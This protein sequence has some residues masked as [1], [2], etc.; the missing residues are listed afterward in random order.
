MNG[1]KNPENIYIFR[2]N[3]EGER[4]ISIREFIKE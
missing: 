3:N 4:G 2:K 1:L